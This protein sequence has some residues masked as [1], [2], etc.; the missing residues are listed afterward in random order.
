MI[1]IDKKLSV[2]FILEPCDYK[3]INID[4][5]TELPNEYPD[6]FNEF[7]INNNLKP[8]KIT[9]GNGKALSVMLKYKFCYWNRDACDKFVKKFNIITKDSIQLFNKHNQKGIQTNSGTERGKL[10]IVYPYCL[11]NKFK[12]RKNF[13]FNE[14]EEEKNNEI[15]KIKSTIKA[16]YIDVPNYLWQLGHK[17]PGS[18]DSSNNNLVLQPPIQGK[19]KDNYI[20]I[21]TL[22]KFPMPNKLEIM[23]EKNEITFEIEQILYYKKIFDKLFTS[24]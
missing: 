5:I 4:L 24:I 2:E 8:P 11:S 1:K 22:T 15:D 13:K 6:E 14:T 19:Y 12:M 21:D 16:D 7:C 17:N 20:F 23:I 18:T 10:Y 9:T 3:L